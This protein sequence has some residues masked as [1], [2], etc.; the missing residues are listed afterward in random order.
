VVEEYSV[1]DMSQA[2]AAAG[3]VAQPGDVVLLS[4]ACASFDQFSGFAARGE[5]FCRAVDHWIGA[6][7]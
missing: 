7:E 4:P 1:E 2:V 6:C 3:V 5:A